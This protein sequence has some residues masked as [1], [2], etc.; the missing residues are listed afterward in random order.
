MRIYEPF[1]LEGANFRICSSHLEPIKAEIK[2]QRSVLIEYIKRH[3]Q[4]MDALEPV[5]LV[6]D[7]PEIV[8]RM[9]FASRRVGIGP[10][11]SV[12]GMM[13]QFAA[14]AG[15]VAGATEAI[16]ENGG[17]IYLQSKEEV[18][19]GIYANASSLSGKLAFLLT[20]SQM[21]ISICSS[22]SKMGHSLSFGDCNLA[23]VFAK[24][25]AL[26]DAAATHACNSV[27]KIDDVDPVLESIVAIS[28]ISGA[29][30]IK[31]E[32]IGLAG[33][34][35]ELVKIADSRLADKITIDKSST[36][37]VCLS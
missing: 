6:S 25:A 37:T 29:L 20:P 13:A 27:K 7:A 10:M 28:G 4:F 32:H 26:A 34:L 33:D 23:T 11:A 18:V 36:H 15:L 1:S 30:I 12:A 2:K 19:I 9:D 8:K 24:N 35:P 31:D 17:D 22:S 21:P 3:P 5:Q 14:Q 16:V